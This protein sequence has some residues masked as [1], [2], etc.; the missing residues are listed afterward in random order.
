LNKKITVRLAILAAACATLPLSGARAA[1]PR[2]HTV[3]AASKRAHHP[4]HHA[5]KITVPNGWPR[6]VEIP[7]LKVKAPVESL[8]LSKHVPQKA[9][10]RWGDVAWYNR[11][12]KPGQV[13][14]AAIFGHV[15]STCCPAVFWELK[16]LKPGDITEVQY[17]SGAPVKFK[18]MWSHSYA[19][20]K[21][22]TKFLFG[23]STQRAVVLVTC[24]GIFHTNGTGYDQKLVVYARMILPNGKL[25]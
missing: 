23:Q 14:H 4:A 10:Y 8:D 16:T 5:M 13:G 11:G 15:D 9:P 20:A 2:P 3:S 17:K 6:F 12:P 19:N 24:A 22:P 25:G 1:S 7:K 21:M 18:V